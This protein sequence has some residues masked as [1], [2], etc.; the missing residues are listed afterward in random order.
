MH[1]TPQPV[2]QQNCQ[3]RLIAVNKLSRSQALRGS[4]IYTCVKQ[5]GQ[6]QLIAVPMPDRNQA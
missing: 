1:V 6:E 5:N 2:T 3:E 4:L